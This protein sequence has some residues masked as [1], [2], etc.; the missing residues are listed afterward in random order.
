[1]AICMWASLLNL[2]CAALLLY[3]VTM[4][5][6]K[7]IIPWLA[8]SVTCYVIS[9]VLQIVGHYNAIPNVYVTQKILGKYV[10][11]LKKNIASNFSIS[12]ITAPEITKYKYQ[13]SFKMN[14][15][16]ELNETLKQKNVQTTFCLIILVTAVL[17]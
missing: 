2:F 11:T 10:Y 8:V 12:T 4:K 14:S 15:C 17:A 9:F 1:M 16:M 7:C 6:A 3:G 5:A 13:M